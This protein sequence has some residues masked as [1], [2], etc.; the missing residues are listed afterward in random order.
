MQG[1]KDVRPI[2]KAGSEGQSELKRLD[3]CGPQCSVANMPQILRKGLV[4]ILTKGNRG[5]LQVLNSSPPQKANIRPSATIKPRGTDSDIDCDHLANSWPASCEQGARRGGRILPRRLRLR[6]FVTV[7]G[8]ILRKM[9]VLSL[10][11]STLKLQCS[12]GG[13]VIEPMRITLYAREVD[14]QSATALQ[15]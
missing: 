5:S 12:C 2:C 3:R 11:L 15:S 7:S 1:D 9:L 6:P 13:T 10:P 8:C 14:T 4:D